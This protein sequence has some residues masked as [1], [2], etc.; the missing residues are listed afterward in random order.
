MTNK[1]N[2]ITPV[3]IIVFNRSDLTRK[4]LNQLSNVCLAKLYVVMDGPRLNNKKD[5]LARNEI[6]KLIAE[7]DFANCVELNISEINLGCKNRVISGLS[8]VFESEESAII[9]EDDCIPSLS[10]L[11]FSDYALE[12]YKNDNRVG[13]ISGTNLCSTKSVG[14]SYSY[15]KYSNIWGWA[16]WR[17]TWN[18]YDRNL[19]VWDNNK[20]RNDFR[21]RC[22]NINEYN[23]WNAVF[24]Q[25]KAGHIDTWDYQLWLSLWANNQLSIVPDVNL[26]DNLGFA[27]ENATHTSGS[28]PA[29][30]IKA[31]IINFPIREQEYM[32]PDA[33]LDSNLR[34]LLYIYPNLLVRG[35]RKIIRVLIK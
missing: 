17:R 19:T 28:H 22:A 1:I 10:F 30:H 13:M 16:T 15:S 8:W 2:I 31:G 26:I 9:L 35:W 5:L 25:T 18:S 34:K 11:K 24:T 21:A 29:N 23:Y 3:V 6:K 4:L 20:F 14:N 27:H 7:I 12:K 32:M 33:K